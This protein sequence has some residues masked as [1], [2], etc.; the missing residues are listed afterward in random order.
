[1]KEYYRKALEL[2]KP[3]YH[4][5]FKK[6]TETGEADEFFG[7]YLD[8]DVQAQEAVDMVFTNQARE[9]MDLGKLLRNETDK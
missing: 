9:F 8:N 4:A 7:K 6:F 3:E 5:A 2:V 1:M